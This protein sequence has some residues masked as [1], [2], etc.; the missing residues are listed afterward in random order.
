MDGKAI[1]AHLLKA[2]VANLREFGYPGCTAENIM[3]DEVYSAFF[4]SMLDDNKG[5][6][7][8]VDAEINGLLS[9]LTAPRIQ[10]TQ[11]AGGP[12]QEKRNEN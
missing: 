1:R 2:G 5:K 8:E 3:T 12:L 6:S 11:G 10:P 4:K 7:K 9:G